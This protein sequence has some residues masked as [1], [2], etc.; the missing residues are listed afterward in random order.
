VRAGLRPALALS[1]LALMPLTQLWPAEAGAGPASVPLIALWRQLDTLPRW[2]GPLIIVLGMIPLLAGW[3]L[4]RWSMAISSAGIAGGTV[5]ALALPEWGAA[6]AWTAALAA[7]V[8]CAL[9]GFFLYQALIA[10]QGAAL[11]AAA[12]IAVALHLAPGQQLAALLAG[13]CGALCGGVLGWR[14]APL[15][16]II[17]T[18]SAGALMVLDGMTI[19]IGVESDAELLS[20][21]AL[22][23]PLTILP[24]F[25]VQLRAWRR[26]E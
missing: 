3:R 19:L 10:V 21:S 14:V 16:G 11:C 22:V 13:C 20:L 12:L 2:S 7:L 8:I 15:L 5:L 9:A 23:L 17:E 25:Y 26:G 24:G 1:V 18:V 4:I 6:L